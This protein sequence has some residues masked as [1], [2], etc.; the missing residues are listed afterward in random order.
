MARE[1]QLWKEVKA[2]WLYRAKSDHDSDAESTVSLS[3][4]PEFEEILKK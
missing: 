4:L 3:K 2:K 1:E